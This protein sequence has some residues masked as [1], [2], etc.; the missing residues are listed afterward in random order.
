MF[1][2]CK[3]IPCTNRW[4]YYVYPRICLMTPLVR[5]YANPQQREPSLSLSTELRP[6]MK[7][8]KTASRRKFEQKYRIAISPCHTGYYTKISSGEG[9]SNRKEVCYK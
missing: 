3:R 9:I 2:F 6:F 4:V 8:T 5:W 1:F 7:R